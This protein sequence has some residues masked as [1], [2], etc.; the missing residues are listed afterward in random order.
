ME[1]NLEQPVCAGTHERHCALELREKK[2]DDMLLTRDVDSRGTRGIH[3]PLILHLNPYVYIYLQ[4][5]LV[6]D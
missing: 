1:C 4:A 3:A 6:D 2:Q 5:K